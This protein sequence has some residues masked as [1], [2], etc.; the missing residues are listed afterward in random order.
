MNKNSKMVYS[1]EY[2][3]MCP[4]CEKPIA[5]CT[6]KSPKKPLKK[7][8]AI[9]IMRETKGR[10]GKGVSIITGIPLNQDDLRILSK[11]LKQKCGSGGTVKNGDIEIQGDHRDLLIKELQKKGYKAKKSGG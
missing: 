6:C 2:G 1:S 4:N 11:E 3:R 9:R 8:G 5:G 7:D 10:K